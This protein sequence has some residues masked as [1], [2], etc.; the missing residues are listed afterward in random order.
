MAYKGYE[1]QIQILCQKSIFYREYRSGVHIL[2][3]TAMTL[4]KN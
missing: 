3:E 2:Y 4:S 1:P